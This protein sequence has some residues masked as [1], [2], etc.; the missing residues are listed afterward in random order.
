MATQGTLTKIYKVTA[1]QWAQLLNG[2]SVNGH[3]YDPNALYL[4][5]QT[6]VSITYDVIS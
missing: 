2:Q 1:A 3:S 6:N 4:I 5:E